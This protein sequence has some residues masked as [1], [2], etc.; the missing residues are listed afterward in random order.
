M[1]YHVLQVKTVKGDCVIR[2]TTSE[3]VKPEPT[4]PPRP[5]A[6]TPST[7]IS[8]PQNSTAPIQ[9]PK[10]TSAMLHLSALDTIREDDSRKTS[11]G[12][13]VG[14]SRFDDFK[15]YTEEY[16]KPA[17][18]T[19]ADASNL[20]DGSRTAPCILVQKA[21]MQNM[22]QLSTNPPGK[23][24]RYSQ[25]TGDAIAKEIAEKVDED[26]NARSYSEQQIANK[27]HKVKMLVERRNLSGYVRK[28]LI[29]SAKMQ[30]RVASACWFLCG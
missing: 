15:L 3:N 9:T 16:E 21:S 24:R 18:K 17:E 11:A 26:M 27:M 29:D 6:A 10:R 14:T 28:R 8:E 23:S 13:S 2:R 12:L 25:I 1:L 7:H 19:E 22:P 20:T 4:R 30:N 5:L